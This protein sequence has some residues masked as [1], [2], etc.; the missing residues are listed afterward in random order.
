MTETQGVGPAI[1]KPKEGRIAE[2]PCNGAGLAEVLMV[3]D[4][5]LCGVGTRRGGLCRAVAVCGRMSRRCHH[6]PGLRTRGL[7][8]LAMV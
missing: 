6:A 2:A 5:T 4:R 8:G 3:C 7:R 1:R